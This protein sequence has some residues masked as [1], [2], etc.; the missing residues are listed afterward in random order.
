MLLLDEIDC[1]RKNITKDRK[2]QFT[3][4]KFFRKEKQS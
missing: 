3:M 4:I 1:K 2:E